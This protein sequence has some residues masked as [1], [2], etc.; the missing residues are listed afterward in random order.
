MVT[1]WHARR[2]PGSGFFGVRHGSSQSA[3]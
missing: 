3:G 2:A 1:A